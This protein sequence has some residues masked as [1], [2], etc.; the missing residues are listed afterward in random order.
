MFHRFIRSGVTAFSFLL[1]PNGNA[2][3][4]SE[5]DE[6]FSEPADSEDEEFTV[7]KASKAKKNEKVTKKDKRK[8]APASK[9]EKPPSKPLKSKSQTA[10]MLLRF[11]KDVSAVGCGCRVTWPLL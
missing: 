4:D 6:D 3:T 7:K 5:S 10:G 11:V 2:F 1:C 8:P 9:K